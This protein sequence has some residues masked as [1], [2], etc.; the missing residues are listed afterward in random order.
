MISSVIIIKHFY[1][2]KKYRTFLLKGFVS[3]DDRLKIS[4]GGSKGC[5][6]GE[7]IQQ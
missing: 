5:K 4:I 6:Y 2:N 3:V 1:K 7:S